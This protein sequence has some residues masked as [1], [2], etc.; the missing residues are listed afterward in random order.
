MKE[1]IFNKKILINYFIKI[2]FLILMIILITFFIK[3]IIENKRKNNIN[4][5][6]WLNKN[7]YGFK[8]R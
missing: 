1:K 3:N 6:S 4:D 2:S 7:S 5:T 8:F